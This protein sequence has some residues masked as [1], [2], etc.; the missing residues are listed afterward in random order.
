MPYPAQI[1]R[2]TAID[3]ACALIDAEGIDHLSLG[4]LAAQLG[5]KAPSLYHHFSDKAELLVG[6]SLRTSQG[7]VA[8]IQGA[9]DAA[10]PDDPRARF[11]VMAAAYRAFAF[12]HPAAFRLAFSALAPDSRPDPAL[13]EALA[14]PLQASL[15]VLVGQADSLAA[16]RG[17]W[18]LVHGF[19]TLE[20]NGQFQRGGDLEQTLMYAVDA[21]TIGITHQP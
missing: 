14:L 15:A 11:R 1:D 17:F 13:L 8:A 9:V 5:I 20:L 10:P 18:A 6:V 19:V 3:A 7:L 2:D 4:K 21:Y 16:L 12:A